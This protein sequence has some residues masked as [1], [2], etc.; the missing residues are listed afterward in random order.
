MKGITEHWFAIG[1]EQ[2]VVAVDAMCTVGPSNG[3][4]LFVLWVSDSQLIDD[5]MECRIEKQKQVR[6]VRVGTLLD[7]TGP[8]SVRHRLGCAGETASLRGRR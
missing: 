3:V 6:V 7:F 5:A 8:N 2:R 1:L 4:G